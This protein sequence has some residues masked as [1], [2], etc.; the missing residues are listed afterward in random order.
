MSIDKHVNDDISEISH[1]RTVDNVIANYVQYA[2]SFG[3]RLF[4]QAYI[5]RIL[6]R[7]E[8]AIWPLVIT[9]IFFVDLIRSG[10]GSGGSRY[11]AH[12]LGR[13]DLE[14]V[15]QITTSLFI[16]LLFTSMVYTVVIVILSI[17]FERIF[18]IPE[19][20]E[21]IGPLALLFA[22]L[23]GAVALPFGV[24][25]DGLRASQ[26]FVIL[27]IISL[28]FTVLR[29]ILIL[30]VFILVPPSLIWVAGIGFILA[31]V[32]DLT[33]FFVARKIIPWQRLQWGSFS[34]KVLKKISNFS[35]LVLVTT[36]AGLLYW[37]T[38]NIIINKLLDPSL[39][40]GYTVIVNF[41]LYSYQ[42][43]ALGVGVFGPAATIMHAKWQLNRMARMIFRVNRTFVPISVCIL[44]F[45]ITFRRE[46][47]RV[48]IG[49]MYEE[50]A[51]LFLIFCPALI[52]SVTQNSSAIVPRAFGKMFIVSMMSLVVAI[53]NVLLSLYFVLALKWDLIG[54]AAGTAIVTVIFKMIF[55][56]WYTARLLEISWIEYFQK[57]V[58][59]PLSNSLPFIIV[60]ISM[61]F[62][63]FTKGW[64][65]LISILLVGGFV[66]LIYML[67]YGLE[68]SDRMKIRGVFL[69]SLSLLKLLLKSDNL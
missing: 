16:A 48:Y 56:P 17:Y 26:K 60:M 11:I 29:L 30:I 6:G 13:K 27:N 61:R 42:V 32:E 1:R 45:L 51:I 22:G 50:Y 44:F 10:I 23:T 8:Y 33:F 34:W 40:T 18:D 35:F 7:S 36:V 43:T 37:K 9:C 65:G 21:G 19:G 58:L 55:W 41:V 47:L 2:V 31:I 67:I 54:V 49:P 46:I 3:V 5:I 25:K 68:R 14:E 59:I 20:T 64:I 15:E 28:I 52:L 63:N 38:D 12:A 4:L 57:S 62:I 69:K 39:L 66:E 53:L 24:F